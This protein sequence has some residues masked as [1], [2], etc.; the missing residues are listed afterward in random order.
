MKAVAHGLALL[1]L[2]FNQTM[3]DVVLVQ[4]I[5]ELIASLVLGAAGAPDFAVQ[6]DQASL[7]GRLAVGAAADARNGVD[8]RQL[9]IFL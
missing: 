7:A 8:H 3:R 1:A 4:K 2:E 6:V 5:V 9:M